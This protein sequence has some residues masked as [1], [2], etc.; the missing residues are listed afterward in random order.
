MALEDL[1]SFLQTAQLPE[2][3]QYETAELQDKI[4]YADQTTEY[5]EILEKGYELVES[6]ELPECYRDELEVYLDTLK[7]EAIP[8]ESRENQ[9]WNGIHSHLEKHGERSMILD[10]HQQTE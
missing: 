2:H 6:G 3:L 8:G 1:H 4:R 10:A 5:R 7:K 9:G